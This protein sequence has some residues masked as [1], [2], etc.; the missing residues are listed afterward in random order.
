MEREII[1]FSYEEIMDLWDGIYFENSTYILNNEKYKKIKN[2]NTSEFSDGESYEYIIQRLS[3]G[4][5]FKFSWWEGGSNG[6]EFSGGENE[7][8]EVFPEKIEEINYK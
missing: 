4:K 6:Y 5:F 3:D 1:K 7:L 8:E 2:I